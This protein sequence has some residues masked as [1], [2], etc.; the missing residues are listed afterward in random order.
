M[1]PL[2][3]LILARTLSLAI[4]VPGV[5]IGSAFIGLG[6]YRLWLAWGRYRLCRDYKR[7]SGR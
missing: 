1:V 5:L 4:T 3:M 7:R 6:I 2:G